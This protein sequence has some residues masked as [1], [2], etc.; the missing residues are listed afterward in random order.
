MELS[1]DDVWQDPSRRQIDIRL[2]SDKSLAEPA[3]TWVSE[4]VRR[5]LI[6]LI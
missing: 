5:V 1:A 2:R 4:T 3:P 6:G